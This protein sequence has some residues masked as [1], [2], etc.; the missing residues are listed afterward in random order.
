MRRPTSDFS[1]GAIYHDGEIRVDKVLKGADLSGRVIRVR[2]FTD[3][4]PN[5]KSVHTV[6]CSEEP[7]YSKGERVLAFL[8]PDSTMYNRNNETDHYITTGAMQGKYSLSGN[9]A[10]ARSDKLA[11]QDLR[12]IVERHKNDPLPEY[13]RPG[14]PQ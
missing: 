9:T 5:G 4:V 13:T 11:L 10:Y 7:A 8:S 6:I 1:T 3:Q 14:S 12:S 2:V